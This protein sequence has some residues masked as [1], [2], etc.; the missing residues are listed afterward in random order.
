M[1]G[2]LIGQQFKFNPMQQLA[3]GGAAYIGSGA[4]AYTEVIQ[5]VW[6]QEH[7]NLEVLGT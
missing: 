7:S 5:K 1:A 2:F 4:W 3:V 6:R